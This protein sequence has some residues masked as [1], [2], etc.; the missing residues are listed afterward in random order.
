MSVIWKASLTARFTG[1]LY[2]FSGAHIE[3]HAW[4]C[5]RIV[6]VFD[7]YNTDLTNHL[8]CEGRSANDDPTQTAVR[9][10]KSTRSFSGML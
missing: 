6:L 7:C 9:E 4:K 2:T 3:Q 1:T 10:H 5:Q 8:V